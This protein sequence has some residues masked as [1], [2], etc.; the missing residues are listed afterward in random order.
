MRKILVAALLSIAASLP[1]SSAWGQSPGHDDCARIGQMTWGQ[2]V[3][4]ARGQTVHWWMWA[5]DEGVNRYVDQ[6]VAAKAKEL[7]DITVVRVPIKDTVEGVQQVVQENQAGK[8]E[9]G[10]VD[11]NWI[12]EEN[13][14]TLIQGNLLCNGYRDILPNAQYL[15]WE[16]RIV[17][18][19]GDVAIEDWA[20]PWGVYQ[21]VYVYNT[22][23]IPAAEIP[24]NFEEFAAVAAK[25]PG[26]I[27]YSAPPDFT[28]RG[29]VMNMFLE[30]TG[31][32]DQ[33]LTG[34]FNEALWKQ[35]QCVLWDYLNGLKPNLWRQGTTYPE[36]ISAQDQLYSTGELWFTISAYQAVPG[37]QVVKGV[38]PPGTRT[39]VVDSGTIAGNHTIGM[40]YNSS[41][42]AATLVLINLLLSP[43]AQYEKALPDVWGIGTILDL[44]RLPADWQEKFKNI[45]R[46]EA[47]LD[48]VT[49]GQHQVATPAHYNVPVE[50]GWRDHVVRGEPYQCP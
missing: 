27:T 25:Y 16:S 45:P 9:D 46:H 47:T 11:L 28:G 8:H 33:W 14:K 17:A 42:K 4:E 18:F 43:E 7:Y 15:D 21:Y 29:L 37:R 30:V 40:P 48:P 35:K 24:R 26:R 6:W 50:Q 19:D 22:D 3:Q 41:S 5:G 23:H 32:A 2:I 49:L 12:S 36:V 34:E 38:F 31:G 39:A 10:S 44:D 20:M 1:A 13:L